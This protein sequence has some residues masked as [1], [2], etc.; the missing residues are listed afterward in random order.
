MTRCISTLLVCIAAFASLP[1]SVVLANEPGNSPIVYY[2][3]TP[4]RALKLDDDA[5]RWRFWDESQLVFAL[6]GLVNRTEPRL[7]VRFIADADDF[8]WE[9][10]TGADGWLAGRKVE[11]VSS[12]VDLLTRFRDAYRGVVVW[13]P[14]VP[15][16]SNLASTIAGCDDLLPVRYDT[17]EGSLYQQLVAAGPQLAVQSRLMNP[18]GTQLFTGQGLVAGTKRDSTGSAKND[19]YIWLIEN[20]VRSGKANPQLLG[21]YLDADWHRSWRAASPENHTLSN[22]DFVIARRGV[23]FDLNVWDDETCVDDRGQRPGTDVATLKEL[24]HASY[25]RFAGNG[26]IHAA[27]FVPWAYKYTD[28]AAAGGTHEAVPTEWRYAEILSCYNAYMDADA[29]GLGA[30]A[31]ASFF[32][33][34]PLADHYPQNA[35][36]TRER[37][38]AQGVLDA[39]GRIVPRNYVAHYVGDYDA[40][41]WLYRQLPRMWNDPARGTTPLT[42]AFNPNLCIRFPL[43]MA[44]ARERR[45]EQDWFAAGDSGAGYLNPGNLSPPRPHSGLPSGWAAWEQHCQHYYQQ[46][47][48]SLTGFV[49][50]G[51][52]R[53]LDSEG[54]DAFAR[55]S[56]D[57]I[58]G[59]KVGRQGVH[60]T[61]PYIRMATDLQGA[62]ADI[63]RSIAG[64]VPGTPPRFVVCRS[65]LQTP[66]W[67]AEVEAELKKLR[68]DAIRVVDLYTLMWLVREYETH[69]DQYAN[70]AY[71]RA[72]EVTAT[73]G[74]MDGLAVLDVTDGPVK[75]VEYAKRD[76]WQVSGADSQHYLYFQV[77]ESFYRPG[78]GELEIDCAYRD[79]G[80][81][82]LVLE[83]DSTDSAATLGGAYKMHPQVVSREGRGAWTTVSFRLAD[84]RFHKTQNGGADF[85]FYCDGDPVYISR[86]RVAR[87]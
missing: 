83:Y 42:W 35:K 17:G 68:G 34:Y 37:L 72:K 45:S 38:I 1:T 61:M 39:Q 71:A 30:M 84:A 82:R 74:R 32:Q 31:N 70:T 67:Y 69:R 56:P 87:Q 23:F 25:E 41:A 57:G 11:K 4:L 79:E 7:F 43:G 18:D 15:A 40:A 85:R 81:G 21:Y 50:D 19:A 64:L 20:Y 62:P 2:D 29:L 76:C 28:A 80:K 5:Q 8:W 75:T 63:A 26:V 47:D 16:T 60:G 59:Q 27:G 86:V 52:A 51:Y 44:W 13:D 6:Q 54:M 12:L 9:Q 10:M 22:H 65:I 24:L 73:P 14:R 77:D 46:W 33:H 58:V 48:L 53:G 3:L 49:I 55:F 66:T 36:P 78:S